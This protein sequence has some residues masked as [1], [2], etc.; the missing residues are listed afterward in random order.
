[1]AEWKKVV[2]SGSSA[3]LSNLNVDSAVTASFFK[4][5]G[6]ALTNIAIGA[7]AGNISES[8][9][10]FQDVSGDVSIASNGT[11]AIG[12]GVIVNDDINASAAIAYGKLNLTGAVV[13]DDLA[14][15]IANSKL[16]NDGITIA[17]NDTSLGDSIT[18]ATIL[19]GTGVHSGSAQVVAALSGQDVALGAGDISATEIQANKEYKIGFGNSGATTFITGSSSGNGIIEIGD[20]GNNDDITG[21][22]F[23]T[24]N[25]PV[26][27]LDD[28]ELTLEGNV[29]LEDRVYKS[30]SAGTRIS[31]NETETIFNDGGLSIDF[32]VEGD[33]DANLLVGDASTDRVGIGTATP[34]NKLDVVGTVSASAFIGNGSGLTGIIAAGSVSGSSQVVLE[35]ADKTGFTGASSITTLGTVTSG[36]VT[37]ILPSGTIS[38]SA[39]LADDFIDTLGDGVHS[40]SAQVVAALSNQDVNLGTGDLTAVTSSVKQVDISTDTAEAK[41]LEMDFDGNVG[42]LVQANSDN[43]KLNTTIGDFSGQGTGLFIDTGNS[44]AK[45]GASTTVSIGD[46]DGIGNSTVLTVNDSSQKITSNKPI[47]VTGQVSASVLAAKTVRLKGDLPLGD[48]ETGGSN[49][50]NDLIRLGADDQGFF[51]FEFYTSEK[52]DESFNISGNGNV[53]IGKGLDRSGS[54]ALEVEGVISG[55]AISSSGAI[56][57]ASFAGSGAGLTNI[58]NSALTNNSVT[59]TAGDGLSGGGAVSLGGTISV[60]VQVDDSSLEIDS[61]TV[62]VKASGITNAMLGGSIANDKLANDGIT[63]AGND[64]SLGDSITA[65]TILAGSGVLSGSANADTATSSSF[66]SNAASADAV[67]DN[68]VVLGT[69]TTGDYI[70]SLGSGTGVTIGSNSGEGSNPTIA[71][72]YGSNANQAVQGNTTATFTGTANEITVSDSSAQALGGGISVQIGLP[73]DVTIAGTGSVNGDLSVAGNLS[74]GGDLTYINSTDLMVTDPFILLNSGSNGATQGDSGIVF[75]GADGVVNSGNLLFWDKDY[76]GNDGRLSIKNGFAHTTTGNPTADYRIAGVFEGSA[77]NA[78]TA[79]ADHVGNIRVESDEIYIYV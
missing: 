26:L 22:Y 11:A 9:Q 39:Q 23:R 62:R 45:L 64:I 67:A 1:M 46:T 58:P 77:A 31:L 25:H 59:V 15:S 50:S 29:Y 16:A 48:F 27:R 2:V 36:N 49:A 20:Q 14:G 74:V 43:D 76:N 37:A 78:E 79:Q 66:A 72:N 30:G 33:N 28:R 44:A 18:A 40:G 3:E 73:D 21:L 13:N 19:D 75:G 24:Y 10:V 57:A 42:F 63:I 41:L 5:D 52:A 55:S 65:A 69:S 47:E 54:A 61:D 34:A 68:S 35:N 60:A 8:A 51:D 70:A 56:S 17:G 7:L 53:V 38:S 4:G 6:S 71:V 32:R 12:S